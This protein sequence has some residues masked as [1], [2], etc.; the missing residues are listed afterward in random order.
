MCAGASYW[1]QLKKVVYGASDENRG[2]SKLSQNIL[3]PKTEIK[4]GVLDK[5]CSELLKSFFIKKRND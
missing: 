2:F 4:F 5:D 1:T 3:H